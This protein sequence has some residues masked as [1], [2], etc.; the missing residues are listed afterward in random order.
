MKLTVS[1]SEARD[2]IA[3]SH[4]LAN[5]EVFI[6]PENVTQS[7]NRG[8]INNPI[9]RDAI[10]TL[11]KEGRADYVN[12]IAVIKAIRTLTNAGLKEAK[13]LAESFCD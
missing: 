4:S 8:D 3:R 6:E 12:K 1:N 10:A 13:D 9:L 7:P 2:I 5:Y 11:F